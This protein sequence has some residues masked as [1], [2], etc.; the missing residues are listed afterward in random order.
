MPETRPATVKASAAPPEKR[1]AATDKSRQKRPGTAKPPAKKPAIDAKSAEEKKQREGVRKVG[2][3]RERMQQ[4]LLRLLD[5]QQVRETERQ[6]SLAKVLTVP[7]EDRDRPEA[8]RRR[9]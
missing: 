5:E 7:Q 2:E 6:K 4:E 8:M 9:D 1:P 3:M